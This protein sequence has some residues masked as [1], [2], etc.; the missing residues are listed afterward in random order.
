M[1]NVVPCVLVALGA[2]GV[3]PA[4]EKPGSGPVTTASGLVY[5]VVHPGTGPVAAKGDTVLIHETTKTEDGAVVTDTWAM[6]HPIRFELGAKQV[7][8]GLD[9]AGATGVKFFRY[10]DGF[11]HE[12]AMLIDERAATVGTANFDNRSFRL[13]FEVTAI[14]AEPSFV[15]EVEAMFEADLE[16][17][18]PVAKDEYTSKSF[19]FRLAVRLARLTAPVQ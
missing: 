18:V 8:D 2:A 12:K 11:L 6:N 3:L 5:E 15:T 17:C 4:G 19:W 13:N 10:T 1:R 14:V 9:E 16:K 7:I